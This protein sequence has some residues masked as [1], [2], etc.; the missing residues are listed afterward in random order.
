[1]K[2]LLLIALVAIV[3]CSSDDV[4]N[5]EPIK[6]CN[7]NKVVQVSTFNIPGTVQNP[8]IS[9]YSVY[10]TINECTGIQA[11]GNSTTTNINAVPQIGQC[12]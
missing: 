11:Q 4:V 6:D 10:T 1:M 2:K 9:Y 3:S 8:A 12:K 7:C 5:S